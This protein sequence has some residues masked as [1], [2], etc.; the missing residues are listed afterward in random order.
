MLRHSGCKYGPIAYRDANSGPNQCRLLSCD[1]GT[2][3]AETFL[4]PGGES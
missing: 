1:Q 3:E 2:F 4:R